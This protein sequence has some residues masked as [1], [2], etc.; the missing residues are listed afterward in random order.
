MK[1]RKMMVGLSFISPQYI[2]EAEFAVLSQDTGK[3]QTGHL[4]I[5]L[6]AAL[7][8]TMLFLTGA[9]VYTRWSE[10]AQL[11]YQPTEEIKKQAADSGLS[12][13]VQETKG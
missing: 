5:W 13:V 3:P 9:A 11:R 4:K 1:G 2:E 12:M 8:A 6:I 10:T 7:V